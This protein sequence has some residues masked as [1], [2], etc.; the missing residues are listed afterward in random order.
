MEIEQFEELMDMLTGKKLPEGMIMQHRP[1]LSRREAFSV[2]WFLQEHLNILPTNIE[3]CKI[4]EG[5][6][7]YH[8][9]GFIV[10]GTDEPDAWHQRFNVTREM[11]KQN[12]GMMFCSAECEHQYWVDWLRAER[13]VKKCDKVAN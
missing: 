11:L 9:G 12:D 6:F 7:D 1:Q 8:C 2:I 10:D 3:Q 5:L 13:I 4:C